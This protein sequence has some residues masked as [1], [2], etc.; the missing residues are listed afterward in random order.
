MEGAIQD[1]LCDFF[2]EANVPAGSNDI[3][4]PLQCLVDGTTAGSA[5]VKRDLRRLLEKDPAA[6]LQS[7]CRI[8]KAD[9]QKAGVAPLLDLVWSSGLLLTSLVDPARLP[10]PTAITLAGRWAAFDPMLDIKLLQIGF[11]LGEDDA[12][13]MADIGRSKRTLDI[14]SGLPPNRHV[15]LALAKLLRYPDPFVRSKA[16]LL[17]A[18]A[19]KNPEWVRKML[20]EPDA[21]VRASAVEGLWDA[22]SPFAAALFREAVLDPDQRVAA[23]ALIGLHRCGEGDGVVSDVLQNMV[24]NTDPQARAAAAFA[25]GHIMDAGGASILET[26]LRDRDAAVRGEAL[27]ALIQIRRQ[28][29]PEAAPA[30]E[31][32][33]PPETPPGAIAPVEGG[34]PPA[35][36]PATVESVNP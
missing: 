7:A 16:A 5:V 17:Y 8:L 20:A 28:D 30:P 1:L 11:P 33:L 4:R 9:T 2:H 12:V 21:R 29:R 15:L 27:R 25:M 18:R 6:F 22:R 23:H 31:A 13:W 32:P 26:L 10:L 35:P 24:R 36:E 34:D 14:V 19:S 3:D